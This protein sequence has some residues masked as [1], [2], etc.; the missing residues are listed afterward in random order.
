M[1][2]L[3]LTNVYG[4]P[5]CVLPDHIVGLNAEPAEREVVDPETKQ[6]RV[7]VKN[8]TRV[9]LQFGQQVLVQQTPEQVVQAQSQIMQANYEQ[10]ISMKRQAILATGG[11]G[12]PAPAI[13]P[14]MRSR[15]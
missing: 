10:M 14:R 6:K 13:P 4:L 1:L 9:I 5:F 7:E 15:M 8:I 11:A 2:Y 12:H 3:Q